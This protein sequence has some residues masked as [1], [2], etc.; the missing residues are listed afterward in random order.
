[1]RITN[2]FDYN[3]DEALQAKA[4]AYKAVAYVLEHLEFWKKAVA[5][6]EIKGQYGNSDYMNQITRDEVLQTIDSVSSCYG[7]EDVSSP[8]WITKRTEI[9]SE[10]VYNKYFISGQF[11]IFVI[12]QD[13]QIALKILKI[14]ETDSLV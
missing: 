6:H 2:E 14:N 8:E 9:L 7:F 11:D 10:A 13:I 1:M 5:D 4:G 12:G 3:P